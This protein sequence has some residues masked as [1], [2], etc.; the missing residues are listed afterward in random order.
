MDFV[1]R[2]AAAYARKHHFLS[3]AT[4]FNLAPIIFYF[5]KIICW[6]RSQKIKMIKELILAQHNL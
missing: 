4:A 1:H 3:L 2:F 6:A 5:H